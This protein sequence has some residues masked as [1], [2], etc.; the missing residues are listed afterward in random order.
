MM[1][2]GKCILLP[3]KQISAIM[4]QKQFKLIDCIMG[5]LVFGLAALVYCCTVEPT[6]SL[7]DCPEFIASAYKLEV[8]HP[9]GAPFFMLT[10]N[11]FTQ[12]ASEPSQV[13]LM[14][15]VMSALLSAGCVALLFLSVSHLMRRLLCGFAPVC[16]RRDTVLIE[17]AALVAALVC[18]S[19]D[20][21]WYSA[22]EAEVYAYSSFFTAL[23][24][25]LMLRWE[26]EAD[27]EGAG[28][29]I[30]LISYF[31]GLS[32]GVHLLNLLCI[33]AM[34][35][36]Y[37]FRRT[38]HAT[39]MGICKALA[40]GFLLLGG[41]LYAL[42]PGFLR[43][44]EWAELLAVNCLGMPFNSGL[45]A[46]AVVLALL[47]AYGLRRWNGVKRQVLSCV[48]LILAGFSSYAV[49]LIRSSANPPMDENSPED[50]FSLRRYLNREQYDDAPLFYGHT[51]MGKPKYVRQGDNMVPVR[52]ETETVYEK[53]VETGRYEEAGKK[54]EYV[55]EDNMLFP[56]MH[57]RRHAGAYR[58]WL[59][60]AKVPTMKDNIRFFV[61]YQLYFMYIRYFLWNFVG[62]QNDIPGYGEV[63][64]G[65][66]I[67]GIDT[68]DSLLL[69]CDMASLP[70][71]LAGNK[72]R[73][74][75]Y[76]LPLL[77]GLLGMLW[78]R[79]RGGYGRAQFRIVFWLFFMTGIAIVL[80]LNQSPVQARERD[81]SYA[82]S[83]YAFSI[84]VGMGTAAV[85]ALLRRAKMGHAASAVCAV[86]VCLCVPALM[87]V[88]NWDDHDRSGRYTCRDFGM[89]YL[90]SAQQEGC[91]VVFCYGDNETFPLWYNQ[92]VEGRRTDVRACNRSYATADWYVDQ[93]RRPAYDSPA[94]PLGWDEADYHKGHG[95]YVHVIPELR[96]RVL[97]LYR[98]EPQ[99]MARV[100]GEKPF[101]LSG[102]L[103]HWVFC[104]EDGMNDE[105]IR[106]RRYVKALVC[107][108]EDEWERT[109]I[110]CIPS[111]SAVITLADGGSM[112]LS[113]KGKGGMT[114]SDLLLLQMLTHIESGRPLY[115]PIMSNFD[116]IPYIRPYLSLEGLLY[117][118]M[119][120]ATED[121]DGS[122]DTGRMY[123]NVMHRFSYG[124]LS[125]GNVY[126]DY[127]VRKMVTGHYHVL[128]R[129]TDALLNEGHDDRALE[130]TRLWLRELPSD[131]VPYDESSL[132]MAEC[133][134]R[135][136]NAGEG[137]ALV[138]NLLTRS[139]EW[140]KWIATI[141]GERRR[142]SRMTEYRWLLAMDNAMK[143]LQRHGR[144]ELL[145]RFYPDYDAALSRYE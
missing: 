1:A 102:I 13:A 34:V 92:E 44:A 94:L 10:A 86:L 104:H 83:F 130:V 88:R 14:V 18:M 80:Y 71:D 53:S 131:V 68:L 63:E 66:W 6:A 116:E 17:G 121:G 142:G 2:G 132:S 36:I 101:E 123:D 59:G 57:S 20:S 23:V 111:D 109:D 19:C 43:L 62:R 72:G 58:E 84:W 54:W 24:F 48:V 39:R 75:Y 124:G 128:S 122:V 140:Q 100:F 87:T 60:E 108:R 3:E 65:N 69:G 145:T 45:A 89:N 112:P 40:C 35:L 79:R 133:L 95:D 32:I 141:R 64:H 106:L 103:K 91:P 22:V 37:Y 52:K 12:F 119:P 8:G 49:I 126:A 125:S 113:F 110:R 27:M 135:T 73:N 96:E 114:K 85:A 50:V 144:T 38:E 42:V 16:S 136:G 81:Y 118:I 7:W 120:A 98:R 51:Y 55:Y 46:L 127:D 107:G 143:V 99:T 134:Y 26:E 61:S 137:D 115:V 138:E 41:V 9:P 82:G 90:E 21:F 15:N 47:S 74:A 30:W 11:L 28:R 56:R 76:G 67:T 31:I 93:M 33:P 139:V 97:A 105:D 70:S 25:W 78:Q 5:W 129:L 117:R 29:W 77:L 4:L